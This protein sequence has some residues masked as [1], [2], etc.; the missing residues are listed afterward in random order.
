MLL[1]PIAIQRIFVTSLFFAAIALF[2][3][4]VGPHVRAAAPA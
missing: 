1:P 3:Y 2:V 4:L